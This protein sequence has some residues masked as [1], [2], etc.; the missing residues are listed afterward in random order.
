MRID[1]HIHFWMPSCGFDNRPVADHEAYR[2][3]FLPATVADDLD[4]ARID[5]VIL[6]QT[7]PQ[8]AETQWLLR[9]AERDDRIVGVTGWVDLDAD[10]CDFAPLLAQRKIVGIRAQLRRV[11]DSAFVRRPRV[12][13]NLAAALEKGLALTILA[14][15]RHH[16]HV[17][18]ILSQL[19]AG[20]ITVNHLG[21]PFPEVDRARWRD[22]LGRYTQRA[23]VY[24][25]FSGLPFLFG[26]HWRSAHA[27]SI[28]DDAFG[29]FGSQRL[30]FASDWPMLVRFASYVE[31]VRAV[32]ALMDRRNLSAKE[33]DAIF[34]GNA[35]R[36]HPRLRSGAHV[37]AS[38][39]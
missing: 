35:L 39:N 14:E 5:G 8:V 18:A 36:A 12:I 3:D 26:E 31:W 11:A 6:V 9:L 15:E 7:C 4:A 20:P 19:P 37:S 34:A 16:E 29:I 25:Q 10:A 30:M 24:L 13:R 2:R 33:R 28:L 27:Q 22:H 1:A 32:E 23:D 21:L 38:D 17:L